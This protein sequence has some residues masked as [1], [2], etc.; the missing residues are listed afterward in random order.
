MTTVELVNQ[1]FLGMQIIGGRAKTSFLHGTITDSRGEIR[2][3]FEPEPL[4]DTGPEAVRYA[5]IRM[6]RAARNKLGP[7]DVV[8]S[9]GVV[10]GG[11][12][13]KDALVKQAPALGE[14]WKNQ[15]LVQD[16]EPDFKALF[17][18]GTLIVAANDANALAVCELRFPGDD[19]PFAETENFAVVLLAE[20]G[21]GCGLVLNNSL[22]TG[23]KGSAGEV[24]H[25]RA[26][27]GSLECNCGRLGCI[28][29]L[30]TAASISARVQ[31]GVDASVARAEGGVALGGGLS[32]VIN[33]LNPEA[34]LIYGQT[35][36]TGPRRTFHV[37][38]N[39]HFDDNPYL[40]SMV[41]ELRG[42]ISPD[43]AGA[44]PIVIRTE[45]DQPGP[46]AAAAVA[47]D[48]HHRARAR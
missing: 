38:S 32:A 13:M 17:G 14:K 40:N 19:G 24:G 30:A 41:A 3:S 48:A 10:I 44:C 22:Y 45:S 46:K 5:I 28:E 12:V 29:T 31:Q 33:L 34:V 18:A 42:H 4:H 6:A 11:T 37:S 21:L 43:A 1:R 16:L 2:G 20:A 36:T 9:S 39:H 23:A 27:N 8:V 15:K 7:R 25:I 26:Q 35:D 47:I